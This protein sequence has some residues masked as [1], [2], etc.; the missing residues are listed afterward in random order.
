MMPASETRRGGLV[1]RSLLALRM[2]LL[3]SRGGPAI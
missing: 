1:L 3:R 2:G